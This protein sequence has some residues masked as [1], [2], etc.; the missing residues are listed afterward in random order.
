AKQR[1]QVGRSRFE[2]GHTCLLSYPMAWLIDVELARDRMASIGRA[3]QDDKPAHL[4][5]ETGQVGH[6][7]AV[8]HQYQRRPTPMAR[9]GFPDL[10]KLALTPFR[11]IE[12]AL[13]DLP[14]LR[15]PEGQTGGVQTSAA[16]ARQHRADRDTVLPKRLANPP[17]LRPPSFVQIA[18]RRAVVEPGVGR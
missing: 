14:R 2:P 9:D 8:R 3:P 4:Y 12:R 18:L 10:D 11:I 6:H 17:G 1:L 7:T 15:L 5:V 16:R 13:Q